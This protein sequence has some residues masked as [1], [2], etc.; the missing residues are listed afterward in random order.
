V[1]YLQYGMGS[2]GSGLELVEEAA[3]LTLAGV[4][5]DA[6][7]PWMDVAAQQVPVGPLPCRVFFQLAMHAEQRY[8]CDAHSC[9]MVTRK[10]VQL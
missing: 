3:K 10:Q 5:A 1:S 6:T 2:T 9:A 4:R 7:P 8:R